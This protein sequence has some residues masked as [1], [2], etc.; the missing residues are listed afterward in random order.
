MSDAKP[1]PLPVQPPSP[2]PSL[3]QVNYW[4]ISIFDSRT[5]WF[6]AIN[7]IVAAGPPVADAILAALSLPEVVAMIPAKYMPLQAAV[8]AVGNV[9]LR[10]KTVRPAVYMDRGETKPVL[11]PRLGPPDPTK[12]TD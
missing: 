7:L 8:V 5:F 2:A 4:G 6:N 11:V 10:M 3:R 12:V 9:W 1:K